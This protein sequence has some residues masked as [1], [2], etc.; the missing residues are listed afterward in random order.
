MFFLI[1]I[2]DF[3]DSLAFAGSFAVANFYGLKLREVFCE[4]EPNTVLMNLKKDKEIIHLLGDVGMLH[5]S[6]ISW[7]EALGAWKQPVLLFASP[8]PSGDIQGVVPAYVSLCKT[9]SVPLAGLIQVG[10]IWDPRKRKLDC[11]PWLGHIPDEFFNKNPDFNQSF[12]L[13]RIL[14]NLKTRMYS[15]NL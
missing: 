6:G 9:F 4:E 7:I 5:P 8:L 11:L 3:S 13:E 10:G 15:L 12:L 2:G 14:L 1:K